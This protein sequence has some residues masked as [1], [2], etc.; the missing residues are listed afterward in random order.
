MACTSVLSV[1]I[2][3]SCD[4]LPVGNVET[5]GWIINIEDL[6]KSGTTFLAGNTLVATNL[7]MV[8]VKV[9]FPVTVLKNSLGGTFEGVKKEY[10]GMKYKHSVSINFTDY[11]NDNKERIDELVKSNV[12]IVLENKNKTDATFEIYGYYAGLFADSVTRN[13][14][15]NDGVVSLVMSSED[16][17]EDSKMPLSFYKTDYATSLAALVALES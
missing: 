6:D 3:N 11:N 4:S 12:V 7:V 15:E 1:A 16:G 2:T 14:N 9:A 10:G 5:K 8:G 17:N 13:T